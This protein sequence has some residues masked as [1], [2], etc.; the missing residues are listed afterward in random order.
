MTHRSTYPDDA[1][2]R[3]ASR[4]A[5][6]ESLPLFDFP[7]RP[8]ARPVEQP[9]LELAGTIAGRYAAWRTT[10]DGATAF[11][12]FRARALAQA[13][14][15]ASRLSSSGI[16]E[17]IRADLHITINNDFRALM[18]REAAADCPKL[19]GLFRIRQ[20]TAT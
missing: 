8:P 19:R 14:L 11:E 3:A 18:A 20:R 15:G 16:V 5:P 6:V 4:P 7:K 9:S 17:A 2:V 12:S 13:A 10:R 1:E